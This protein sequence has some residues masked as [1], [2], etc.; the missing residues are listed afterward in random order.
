MGSELCIRD[1]GTGIAVYLYSFRHLLDYGHRTINV[2]RSRAF[3]SDGAL[4]F[5]KRLGIEVTHATGSG[6]TLRINNLS[7]AA[8]QCLAANPFIFLSDS[9]LHAAVF[10]EANSL[11]ADDVWASIWSSYCMPGI[12]QIALFVLDDQQASDAIRVPDEYAGRIQ[13]RRLANAPQISNPDR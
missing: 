4:Y 8:R 10:M 12:S 2:G 3:L 1:R 7:G 13:I 5:K 9:E 6:Y 11:K